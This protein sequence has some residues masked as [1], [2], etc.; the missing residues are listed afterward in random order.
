REDKEWEYGTNDTW[1]SKVNYHQE[2]EKALEQEYYNTITQE[3]EYQEAEHQVQEVMMAFQE[4]EL[5][6]IKRS[7]KEVKM[8]ERKT[9]GS[10]GYNICTNQDAEIP[11]HEYSITS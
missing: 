2:Q 9:T 10:V 5:L 4:P 6:M 1:A 8:P 7:N 3:S 11:P